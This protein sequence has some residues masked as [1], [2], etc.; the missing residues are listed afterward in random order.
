[1][2]PNYPSDLTQQQ[3]EC[4]KDLIPAAKPG[5]RPRTLDMHAVINGILYVVVGGIQWRMLPKEYPAWK[6][7]YHYFWQWSRNGIWKRIHDAIRAVYR[8]QLGRHKH[9]TAGSIDSQTVKAGSHNDIRGYDAGKKIN[10]RKRHIAVDTGG[11]LLVAAVTSAAVQDRDGARL[12]LKRI[13]GVGKK[14]MRLWVDSAYQGPL[15]AWTQHMFRIVLTVVK[16]LVGQQGF[17]VLPRRWVVE[18]TFGWFTLHRRL[19]KDYEVKT[20]HS[21]SMLYLAML[22]IMLRRLASS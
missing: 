20:R 3:W 15:I 7:V 8:R 18:R 13:G 2:K 22:R 19:V 4:I 5:G 14:L 17:V 1:M 6:S 16:K 21:E 12:V 10:G 9:P 11:L